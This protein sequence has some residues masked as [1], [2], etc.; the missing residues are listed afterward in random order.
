MLEETRLHF[1][2]GKGMQCAID[3]VAG[4]SAATAPDSSMLKSLQRESSH[5][6]TACCEAW[7]K[8]YKTA[9]ETLKGS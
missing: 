2:I 5:Q 3:Q 8:G 9:M 7:L 6:R 1:Y 4:L